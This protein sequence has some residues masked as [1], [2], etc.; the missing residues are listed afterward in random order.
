MGETPSKSSNEACCWRLLA[1]RGGC[2]GHVGVDLYAE[3]ALTTKSDARGGL[4]V[5]DQSMVHDVFNRPNAGQSEKGLVN[6]LDRAGF[7]AD[8]IETTQ[9]D[10]SDAAC[11]HRRPPG[12]PE[13]EADGISTPVYP[14][15]WRSAEKTDKKPDDIIVGSI[16]LAPSTLSGLKS[17]VSETLDQLLYVQ[18]SPRWCNAR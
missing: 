16:D 3:S 7:K 9:E 15:L 10:H 14:A 4:R 17:V 1:P 8:S 13:P 6:T 2:F 5:S 18:D 12:S 11:P